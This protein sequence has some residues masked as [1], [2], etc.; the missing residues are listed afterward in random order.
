MS[1]NSITQT[2]DGSFWL[3]TENGLIRYI[4]DTDDYR[5]FDRSDGIVE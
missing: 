1:I 5:I 2:Y 4:R 3:G